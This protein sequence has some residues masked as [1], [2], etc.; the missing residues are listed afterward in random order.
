MRHLYLAFIFAI[1]CC[2]A[3]YEP[4]YTTQLLP[5]NHRNEEV[6]VSRIKFYLLNTEQLNA[7]GGTACLPP[8]YLGKC[9]AIELLKNSKMYR[10]GKNQL[11]AGNFHL[12]AVKYRGRVPLLVGYRQINIP[13]SGSTLRVKIDKE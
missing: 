8:N 12:F 5:V 3:C 9:N 11:R 1:G 6:D 4:T 7:R 2:P 10:A 13:D